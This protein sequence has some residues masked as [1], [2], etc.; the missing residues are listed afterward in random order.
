MFYC[1]TPI[2]ET[3]H[4]YSFLG[5]EILL[6]EYVLICCLSDIICIFVSGYYL[7]WR[8]WSHRVPGRIISKT[9]YSVILFRGIHINERFGLGNSHPQYNRLDVSLSFSLSLLFTP[10]LLFPLS[11]IHISANL[12]DL[13]PSEISRSIA[14]ID[15]FHYNYF[16]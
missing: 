7:D 2:E 10:H 1:V 11:R 6:A 8:T 15:L 3:F 9:S 16:Y 13:S 12:P 5:S 14:L 4:F